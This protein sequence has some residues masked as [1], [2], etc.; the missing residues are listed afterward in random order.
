[1]NIFDKFTKF[2]YFTFRN[3]VVWK[4]EKGGFRVKFRRFW[5]EAESISG[6]WKAKW[7]AAEYPYAY[8]LAAATGENE[9][10]VWGYVERMYMWS[11]VLLTS[12][13]LAKDMDAAFEAYQKRL[14]PQQVEENE[15]EEKEALEQVKEVQEYVETPRR[16]RRKQE[17]GVDGRFRAAVKKAEKLAE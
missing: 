10:T 17:R 3:K 13:E 5:V 7:T 8:L 1:M 6:N 2:W 15:E 11:M 16:H 14:E 12:P 9:Q 4:G